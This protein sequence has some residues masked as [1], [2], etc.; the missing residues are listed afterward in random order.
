MWPVLPCGQ[1]NEDFDWPIEGLLVPNSPPMKKPVCKTVGQHV[2]MRLRVLRN[3]DKNKN[4]ALIIIGPDIS[5]R[6]KMKS[7]DIGKKENMKNYITKYSETETN[8]IEFHQL[9]ER[10]TEVLNLPSAA[11]RLFNEKGKEIFALKDLQRDELVYVSCGESWINPHLSIAQQK[12]Q[13]FLRSLASDISKIQTFCS[14]HTIETLVLEIQSDIVSGAKLAVHKPVAIFGEEKQ[15]IETEEEQRQKDAL[16]TD[17]SS[18]E[19]LDSHARAHFRMKACHTLLRYAWQ[20]A[21]HDFD[22]D[23]SPPEQTEEEF[24]ELVEAPKEYSH[25]PKQSK[26][27]K[28]CCQQ[29]EYRDG[30]I[31]SHVV[32]QLVLGVEGPNLRPGMEVIL[33]EKKAGNSHQHWIHKKGSRTFHLVSNPDLVL[34]VSLTKGRDE[35]GGYPVIVQKYK[36]HNNGTSN[37]KWRY[38]ENMK[39]FMAFHSTTLD[40]EI[41]AAN[42]AGICTSSVIKEENIDQPGYYYLS[43]GKKKLMFCLAC[44]RSMRAEKGLKQLLPGVPFLCASG[45]KTLRPSSRG[46]FKVISVAEADLSSHEAEKTRSYYE[47]RLSSLRMKTCTPVVSHGVAAMHQKA[48]KIIA[49]KNGDGYRNGKLIVAGTFPM[50]LAECTEQLGLA[51]AASKVYTKDGTS[52]LSL[53]EL[54][55]WALDESFG[56]KVSEGQ[57]NNATLPGT[58]ETTVESMEENTRMK[59]KSTLPPKS[60][61]S[62]SLEGIDKSLLTLGLRYPV[63]IWVSCGE[64]FLSPNTL[65]KAEKLEKQNWLKKDKILADL[66]TMKHKMRQLKG[67]RVAA[68]QSA[69]MVPSKSPVQPVVVEGGW[70]E[71]TQEEIKLMELIRHTEA[72]LSEIQELQSKRNSPVATKGT[73]HKKSSLYKQPNAKR[74][75]IYLNGGR[76]ADG[77]YAWGKT[78]AE[79]LDDCSSRLKMTQPARTLYTPHGELIQSWDDIERDMVICVSPGDSFVTQKELKRLMEVRANYARIRR[80]QGPQATDIMVSPST[81]LLSLERKLSSPK[82]KTVAEGQ[83]FR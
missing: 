25:S 6:R 43:P 46:P 39:T 4:R 7:G 53:R 66:D 17:N 82:Q 59:V 2:P 76:P 77:T 18:S 79:L 75:W 28:L 38:I 72:H 73:A 47:E 35:D 68:C 54:V 57:K 33:V 1:L 51:R 3:G 69:T 42:Y 34:A 22:E 16:A 13:I 56:Q 81:K 15:M 83:L 24:F 78:I 55:L 64:P 5:P 9:L 45:S 60:V 74:V 41:T 80:L 19:I 49:Y 70:T 32:P 65:Q 21:S 8:Q 37:Q 44:G 20:K 27:Q 12:K 58:K 71:Q 61:T 26:L 23:D 48:V 40:K 67:R 36:P 11:R 10:C 50:L 14:I 30:Q 31:I 52:I 63:P 29:F 62:D